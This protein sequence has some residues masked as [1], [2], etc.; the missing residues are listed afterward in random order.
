MYLPQEGQHL[1]T[2]CLAPSCH[3]CSGAWVQLVLEITHAVGKEGQQ[4]FRGRS[5]LMPNTATCAQEGYI[6]ISGNTSA[7][8]E[9]QA[10]SD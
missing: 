5:Q 3:I 4:L 7:G 10:W 8:G 9:T 1:V 6:S 2:T